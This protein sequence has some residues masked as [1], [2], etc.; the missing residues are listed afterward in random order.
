MPHALLLAVLL[1]AARQPSHEALHTQCLLYAA[2]PKNPW[3]LAHG[4]CGLGKNFAAS[5]GR[6]AADVIVHDFLQK[7]DDP[8]AAAYGFLLYG[9]DGTPIEPH[10][11]LNTKTLVL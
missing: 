9:K 4:I 1:S 11:N 3:A 6:R 8:K 5:D 10:P 2:E 7:G